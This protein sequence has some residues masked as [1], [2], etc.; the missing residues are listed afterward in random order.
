MSGDA[1]SGRPAA[2]SA[3]FTATHW[4]VVVAAGQ[5]DSP[6]AAEALTFPP[7]AEIDAA[8]GA[9]GP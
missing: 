8:E 5:Q 2:R 3:E 7:L 4:G 6:Q 9:R 1:L